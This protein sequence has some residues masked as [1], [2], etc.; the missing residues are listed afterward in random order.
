VPANAAQRLVV[1]ATG[2]TISYAQLA[3][4]VAPGDV[5]FFG[6]QHD[7]DESHRAELALLTAIGDRHARV[8]LS[9][10]MFERDVQANLDAY[11]AGTST[12]EAFRAQSRPWPNYAADYRPLVELAK[13]KGWP[14]VAANVPRRL[15]SVVSRKGLSAVDSLSAT[16]RGWVAGTLQCP[17]D[18][19]YDKFV[20][21]MGGMHAGTGSAPAATGA[22]PMVDLF[23]ESQCVKDETM[24]ESIVQ[25]RARAPRGA[26]VVH[27]NGAFHSDFGL[28]TVSRVAWRAGDAG[29]IVV[30]AVPTPDPAKAK[31]AEFAD[32][33]QYIILARRLKP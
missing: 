30:S 5:V 9:L 29:M 4:R 7:D 28:G 25:A 18:T 6:E 11:L 26:V 22:R 23:Y 14:V 19:Y 3:E 24:A 16:D 17:K 21:V 2:Q 20:A 31:A 10:E 1:S 15:A 27:V 8:V 13:A 12:E 32:R 33:G